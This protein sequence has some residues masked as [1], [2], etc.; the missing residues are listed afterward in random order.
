MACIHFKVSNE[1]GVHVVR[2][3][4]LPPLED[5]SPRR[6]AHSPPMPPP[7]PAPGL[8]TRADL[9]RPPRLLCA[10]ACTA[11]GGSALHVPPT[12]VQKVM[13][14]A[15]TMHPARVLHT[16]QPTVCVVLLMMMMRAALPSTTARTPPRRSPHILLCVHAQCTLL[17][18]RP[19]QPAA[20]SKQGP[21]QACPHPIRL[22]RKYITVRRHEE[23]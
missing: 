13:A 8:P 16:Q 10:Q 6:A 5:S 3:L 19:W 23:L 17:C 12:T 2:I 7:P 11:H 20:A 18:R 4:L 22:R 15:F 21:A 9:S 1:S 14:D